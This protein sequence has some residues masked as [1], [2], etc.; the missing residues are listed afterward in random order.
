MKNIIRKSG[1]TAVAIVITIVLCCLFI[2]TTKTTTTSNSGPKVNKINGDVLTVDNKE[3]HLSGKM[4]TKGDK[5]DMDYTL[6]GPAPVIEGQK[7]TNLKKI[8]GVK[9]IETVPS[10]DTPVCSMQTAELNM[11]APKHKDVTF[12]IISQDLPFAQSRYCGAKGINKNVKVFSDYKDRE[13]SNKNS[14]LVNETQLNSRTILV[15]NEDNK[16]IYSEYA[17]EITKS[18][19]LQK[20]LDSI[21]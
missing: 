20:A 21:K 13:F 1:P 18:L 3:V 17:K 6:D 7:T 12:I 4:L 15:L 8:K 5:V 2:P 14:L 10:L 11:L 9:V 19:D 16:V